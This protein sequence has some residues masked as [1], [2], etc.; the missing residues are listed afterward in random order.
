MNGLMKRKEK[1][2]DFNKYPKIETCF[3]RSLETKK[4]L[5]GVWR[6]DEL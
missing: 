3:Q 4:L 6:S 1:N 2:M 5:D